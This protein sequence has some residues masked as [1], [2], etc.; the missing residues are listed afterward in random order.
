MG[1]S[2]SATVVIAYSMKTLKKTFEQA[3][4]DLKKSRP[5]VQP[6]YGFLQQLKKLDGNFNLEIK[7]EISDI[8]SHL[9]NRDAIDYEFRVRL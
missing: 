8:K 1:V 5:V 9:E 6:N 3:L 4:N 2:R 7:S